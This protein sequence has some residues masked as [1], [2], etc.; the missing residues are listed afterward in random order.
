MTKQY[1]LDLRYKQIGDLFAGGG[2][3]SCAIEQATGLYVD[4]AVNHDEQAISMHTANHPQTIH[5][6]TDVYEVD[7]YLACRGRPVGLLHL[8]PDCTHHSQAAGGQPRDNATRSLSW[9]GKRW[10]AQ[11]RP[12][13]ITLENVEQITRWG[14]LVAK[15][16]KAT[17]RVIKL[18]KTV[19]APGERVPV[20]QQYLVP[21][22][23]QTGKRWQKF[24]R[25]LEK[26]GYVVE[27]RTLV[28]ADYGAPTT[29]K[30]LF[31]V[32]RRDGL[33]IVWPEA[34]HFKNPKPGQ[35]K[36]RAAAECIDW[37]VPGK[38]IFDREKPL[39]EAT[40]RRIAKGIKKFV[41]DNPEP[42]IV[43]FRGDSAGC[44]INQPLST[45]TSGGNPKR[46]AGGAHALGL[47]V[48]A[49]APIISHYHAPKNNECRASDMSA[50]LK[51]QTTENRHGL[52]SAVLVNAA[53]GEGSGENKRRGIGSRDITDA[54]GTVTAS[55]S[56]GHAVAAAYLMQAN[57]GFNTVH[58]KDATEPMSTITNS[59]SQ[60]Q[61]VSACLIRQ[62]GASTGS[63]IAA[64]M[65]TVM[66]DGGGGKTS[67]A[68]CELG[69]TEERA[70]RVASFLINYYG[71]GDARNLSAPM[72]TITTK[73]KLALVTVYVKGVPH[74]IVDITLRM[75][76]PKELYKAQGFPDDYVFDRDHTGRPLT[77]TAQVRMC[78]NSVSPPPMAALIRA[79]YN[80]D[81]MFRYEK[82][83]A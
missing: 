3:A 62:F 36:W 76:L 43:K 71:N 80:P 16:D 5:Y 79:N 67:L 81:A 27:W 24:V 69:D 50:P 61:L 44:S 26:L 7:P 65:G 68:V 1:T 42:F 25:E 64:P 13:V 6:Q 66:T 83:A 75:L 41:L 35:K 82:Q 23:K 37:S 9:A 51:T 70:L 11:V 48:P 59:G 55:G 40:M 10:A 31:M 32:A 49:L 56:G 52:V 12:D 74:Y 21:D 29:R 15:R 46:P 72:D 53:Y 4:F 14:R 57:G 47:A 2:G 33:P 54:L 19:A 38:S 63:D 18:D 17:G 20:Q 30:R 58:G 60:Q 45:I 28:A 73:D 34:T 39:A 77:K 22:P 78:G 8:S